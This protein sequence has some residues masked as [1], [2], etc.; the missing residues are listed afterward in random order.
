MR[1]SYGLL[2]SFLCT[3]ASHAQPVA[4]VI[5]RPLTLPDGKLD[6]TLQDAYTNWAGSTQP[7]GTAVD[8]EALAQY[9]RRVELLSDRAGSRL[10]SVAA[11]RHR[12]RFFFDGYVSSSNGT[13]P[14]GIFD[15]RGLMFWLRVRV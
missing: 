9:E 5:D 3:A 8:G 10:H 11:V 7:S 2:S 13:A 1:I 12:R 6:L 14:I 15:M 4:P